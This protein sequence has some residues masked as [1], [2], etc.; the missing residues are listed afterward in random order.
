MI[1]HVAG[2]P[3]EETAAALL[4]GAGAVLAALASLLRGRTGRTGALKEPSLA[5]DIRG[6]PDRD[7]EQL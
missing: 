1:A 3:V 5:A 6:R 7:G 4:P 2:V